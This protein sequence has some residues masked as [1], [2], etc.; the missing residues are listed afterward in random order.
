MVAHSADVDVDDRD[1]LRRRRAHRAVLNA[2]CRKPRTVR[3]GPA[4]SPTRSPTT[5]TVVAEAFR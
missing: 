5:G 1:R 2:I 3:R 4:T